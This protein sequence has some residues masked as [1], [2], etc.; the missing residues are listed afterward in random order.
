MRYVNP[1]N[2]GNFFM[3]GTEGTG[4]YVVVLKTS[5]GTVGYRADTARG[6]YRVRVEP[7]D[8][9]AA[10]RLAKH[11]PAPQWKQPGDGSQPR[12]SSTYPVDGSIESVIAAACQALEDGAEWTRVNDS[13]PDWARHASGSDEQERAE[14]TAVLRRIGVRGINRRW[15]TATLRAKLAAERARMVKEIQRRKLPGANLASTWST[16]TLFKKLIVK[17][18]TVS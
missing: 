6:V 18:R 14:L 1:V 11:F 7:A 3:A 5:Q 17:K 15:K 4:E 9:A 2:D 12:F 10:E 13:A 8:A 16:D